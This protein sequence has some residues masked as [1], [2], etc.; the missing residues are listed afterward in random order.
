MTLGAIYHA[1]RIEA[2]LDLTH[3][4]FDHCKHLFHVTATTI[5]GLAQ[6]VKE[7]TDTAWQQYLLEFEDNLPKF[8]YLRHLLVLVHVC[9]TGAGS[10]LYSSKKDIDKVQLSSIHRLGNER[11]Q[12]TNKLI[13][14]DFKEWLDNFAIPPILPHQLVKLRGREFADIVRL[15]TERLSSRWSPHEIE[16]IEQEC[17]D[18]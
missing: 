17:Q 5:K 9:Q 2:N 8:C 6:S 1:G 15:Q 7:K 3:E 16:L 10:F 14:K 12:F 18:L 13:Y 11:R 4:D